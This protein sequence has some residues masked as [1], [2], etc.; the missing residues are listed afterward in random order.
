VRN[1]RRTLN[2]ESKIVELQNTINNVQTYLEKE[3]ER[4]FNISIQISID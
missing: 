4:D 1:D 3:K 2:Y